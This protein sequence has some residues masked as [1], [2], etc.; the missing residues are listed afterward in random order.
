VLSLLPLALGLLVTDANVL[1]LDAEQPHARHL[2]V[3]DG[4]FAYVGNDLAAARKA[5]GSGAQ[6]VDGLGSTVVPGFNDAHVHFGLSLTIG[7]DDAVDL[8]DAPASRAAFVDAILRAAERPIATDAHDW[9]F[10]VTRA[11]PEGVSTVKDLPEI[12]RPLFVITEHGGILNRVAQKRLQLT[13]E[14]APLGQVRGRLLPAALDRIVKSLPLNV[15]RAGARRFLAD[16]A[17]LGLT[18]VQLMD[19]LPELFESLRVDGS[20]TARVRM[21]VFGYRFET[22]RYVPTWHAPAPE[23]VRLDAVKYFHDDWARLPRAELRHIYEEARQSG[24]Q[25]VM[26]VLSRWALRS[27]LDQ[28]DEMEKKLPGGARH[29]RIDH[30]DEVT[31]ELAERLKRL[32]IIVCS[33]PAMLPEWRAERAFP[34]HT[35]LQAGVDLCMGSDFVGR[36]H[37]ARPLAPLFGLQMAV[38]HGGYGT[39]EQISVDD[40]LIAFTRG[41]AHAEARQDLGVIKV[42]APADL[43]GLAADP[44]AVAP[45]HLGEIEIRFTLMGGKVVYQRRGPVVHG[46]P[47]S[48]GPAGTPGPHVTRPEIPPTLSPAAPPKE[49]K[50]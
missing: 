19:E 38:T 30:A 36:H 21:M 3:V 44:H 4:K 39:R 8:G 45:E 49:T 34:M 37:P 10:V 9:V 16:A 13:E 40:A 2:A 15:L 14:E 23:L 22:P 46:N 11:A 26:H 18:S 5:A 42:G 32:A 12:A 29:F 43:V 41:S 33:N 48:M 25:V 17:R 35:L 28:L 27:L 31:P 20:L 50:K 24:R 47:P 1:T 6:T 7:A